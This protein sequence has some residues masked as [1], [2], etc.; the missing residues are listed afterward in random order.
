[1]RTLVRVVAARVSAPPVRQLPVDLYPAFT[2][3]R[4]RQNPPPL[5]ARAAAQMRGNQ[6]HLLGTGVGT[7]H[8][9]GNG[10]GTK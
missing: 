3:V 9:R 2:S 8:M 5:R 4:R 1:M 7:R 10:S 6:V